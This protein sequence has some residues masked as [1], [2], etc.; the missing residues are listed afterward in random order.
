[1]S[2]PSARKIL[3]LTGAILAPLLSDATAP[4]DDRPVVREFCLL[5]MRRNSRGKGTTSSP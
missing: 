1:M 5:G 3:R 2:G 4:F